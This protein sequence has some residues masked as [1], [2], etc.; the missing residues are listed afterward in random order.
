MNQRLLPTWRALTSDKAWR[1]RLAVFQSLADAVVALVRSARA[2]QAA[3]L[4]RAHAHRRAAHPALRP[5]AQGPEFANVELAGV[6]RE[7][8]T[9][10]A[11]VVRQHAAPSLRRV[12]GR[13]GR[14][15]TAEVAIPAVATCLDGHATYLHQQAALM[16]LAAIADH[17]EDDG[18]P[19]LMRLWHAALSARVP[20]VRATAARL[21]PALRARLVRVSDPASAADL[22]V[23]ALVVVVV[24]G[25]GAARS[26][27]CGLIG[28]AAIPPPSRARSRRRWSDWP[29]RTPTTRCARSPPPPPR[30]RPTTTMTS[31]GA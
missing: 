21:A 20:S 17:V 30:P 12:A 29:A 15:W 10:V 11:S 24:G 1:V 26:A 5:L 2:V 7:W 14:A 23:R 22:Q 8:L 16:A 3:P 28:A 9:D 18:V 6:L 4:V 13:L 19:T 25:G 27:V 31:C